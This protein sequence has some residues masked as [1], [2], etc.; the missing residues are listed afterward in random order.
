[1]R[2]HCPYSIP[3]IH[4]F[5]SQFID[6]VITTSISLLLASFLI[7]AANEVWADLEL[8][9]K[10]TSSAV[11]K[12]KS[13]ACFDDGTFTKKFPRFVGSGLD[14]RQCKEAC[15]KSNHRY[16][17]R[18]RQGEC[19]CGNHIYAKY[20]REVPNCDCHGKRVDEK[21]SCVF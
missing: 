2:T 12:N 13:V 5:I 15:V 14:A 1:M 7:I 10:G 11:L 6:M 20:R 8:L 3:R 17:E 4:Y 21:K 16:A 9:G 19:W 18:R